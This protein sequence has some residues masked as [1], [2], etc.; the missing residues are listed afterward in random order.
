MTFINNIIEYILEG[1]ISRGSFKWYLL[2]SNLFEAIRHADSDNIKRLPEL[3]GWLWTNAPV[4]CYGNEENVTLWIEDGG[5][6]GKF[7]DAYAATWK[8]MLKE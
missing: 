8:S 7:G 6:I 4:S 5:L 1:T 2:T 3:V